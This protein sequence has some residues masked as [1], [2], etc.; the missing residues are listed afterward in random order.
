MP[1]FAYLNPHG[2]VLYTAWVSSVSD[3]LDDPLRVSL[4]DDAVDAEVVNS[5]FVDGQWHIRPDGLSRN[6]TRNLAGEWVDSR[7]IGAVRALKSNEVNFWRE[8]A[9]SGS[10]TFAGKQ[11]SVDRLGKDDIAGISQEVSLTG[12]LPADFPGG[13]KT[14][15]NSY[16]AIPDVDTWKLFVKAMVA[17]GTANFVHA[18]ALKAQV[19]AATT[20]AEIDAIVW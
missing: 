15:D 3:A 13:W 7:D 12:A 14:V 4:P 8:Q 11:I 10:F 16:V 20:V 6:F 2:S 19:A 1:K 9:N 17:Q 18:Q 5:V